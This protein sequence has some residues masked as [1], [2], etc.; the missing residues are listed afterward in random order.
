MEIVCNR[1]PTLAQYRELIGN[2]RCRWDDAPL[3]STLDTYEHRD[4]WQVAGFG[5]KQWLSCACTKCGYDWSLN[6]LG[7]PRG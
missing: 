2:Q 7:V 3:A 5:A 6:K 4:G 1:A